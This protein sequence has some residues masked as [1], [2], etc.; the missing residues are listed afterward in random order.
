MTE[1]SS[2]KFGWYYLGPEYVNTL[3]VSAVATT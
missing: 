1:Y 2:M 3:N